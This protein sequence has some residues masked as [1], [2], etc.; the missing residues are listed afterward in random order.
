MKKTNS[1]ITKKLHLGRQTI[2]ALTADRLPG[3]AGGM[4]SGTGAIG[5][6]ANMFPYSNAYPTQC[7]AGTGCGALSGACA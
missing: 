2:A 7:L 4:Y 5:G 1:L 6:G 3:V